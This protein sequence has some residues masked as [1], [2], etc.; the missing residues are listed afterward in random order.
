MKRF[1]ELY[2]QIIGNRIDEGYVYNLEMRD[3]IFQQMDYRV[4]S[5]AEK[6]KVLAKY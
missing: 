3:S 1:N 4:Y 2:E 6:E 5:S